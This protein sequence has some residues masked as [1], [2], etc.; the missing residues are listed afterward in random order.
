MDPSF[1]GQRQVHVNGREHKVMGLYGDL[2][3]YTLAPSGPLSG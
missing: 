2:V 3:H 1:P